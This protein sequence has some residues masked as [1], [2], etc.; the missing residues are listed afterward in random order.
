LLI[1]PAVAAEG[2]CLGRV[3]GIVGD[4]YRATVGPGL[5]G[6]EGDADGAAGQNRTDEYKRMLVTL[7]THSPGQWRVNG[8]VSN[9]PEFRSA[10]HCKEDAPMV[11][12]N[13]CGV[14]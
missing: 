6:G 4:G 11:R 2:N 10:F 1:S 9:L 7:D 8:V 3:D 12:Q 5:C 14:W 13:A